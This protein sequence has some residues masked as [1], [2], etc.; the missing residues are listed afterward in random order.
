MVTFAK[1]RL[2]RGDDGML[3]IYFMLKG[4]Y[5]KTAM[6]YTFN[7]WMMFV[8]GVLMRTLMM[9]VAFVLFRNVDAIG[10]FTEGEVYLMMALM[11]ISEGMCNLLFDGIWH[12]PRLVFLGEFDVMLCRPVPVLQ[13]VLSY[14]LG[15]Q[16]VGVLS[17][18]IISLV[19]SAN[20]MGWLSAVNVLLLVFFI[21]SG[22]LLRMSTFLIGVSSAFFMDMGGSN[23]SAFLMYSIGEYAKYPL[24]IY[25]VWLQGVLLSII[26]F[27]FIGFVP[28]LIM[29][30]GQMWLMCLLTAVTVGY[31]LFA[32]ALFYLGVRKY[33]SM[34]M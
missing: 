6:E 11:F 28:V 30:G 31:F 26:P 2:W 15:L 22:M 25:P 13:Q 27:G 1:S 24:G 5:L 14:E 4:Q 9:G 16:G 29:R 34:G 17:M 23:Q 19:M 3:R 7:F 18:G 8:A 21:F 20:A 10:G 12:V 32:R 33:E